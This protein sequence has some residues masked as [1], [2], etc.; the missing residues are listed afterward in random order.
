MVTNKT[1]PT[2][3]SRN[4]GKLYQNPVNIASVRE[5][6]NKGDSDIQRPQRIHNGRTAGQPRYGIL[7]VMQRQD[8]CPRQLPAEAPPCANRVVAD[9]DPVRYD[10]LLL[11]FVWQNKE[12][13]RTVQGGRAPYNEAA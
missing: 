8:A 11:P 9:G 4:C 7:P 12:P 5:Y 6:K 1:I 3:L 10:P 2:K 13:V